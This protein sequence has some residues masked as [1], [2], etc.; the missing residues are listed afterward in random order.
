M[1][2]FHRIFA[3]LWRIHVFLCLFLFSP[4]NR[5]HYLSQRI[6]CFTNRIQREFDSNVRIA[7]FDIFLASSHPRRKT[8]FFK[9]FAL[10]PLLAKR[11]EGWGEG[12]LRANTN[13]IQ[14][15]FLFNNGIQSQ[16]LFSCLSQCPKMTN[17][18]KPNFPFL[19][20]LGRRA[21]TSRRRKEGLGDGGYSSI[22]L[23]LCVRPLSF[24]FG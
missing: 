9:Q 15:E 1:T 23:R 22:S 24:A 12:M 17:L 7:T 14:R 13:R 10:L 11:G 5:P 20:A 8:N 19:N 21:V 4:Q 2:A 6:L 16:K 18:F 3:F